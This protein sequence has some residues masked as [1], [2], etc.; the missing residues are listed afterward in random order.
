MTKNYLCTLLTLISLQLF[1]QSPTLT[2]KAAPMLSATSSPQLVGISPYRLERLDH[3]LRELI[4]QE[5][6]PGLVA[7]ISRKGKIVYEKAYGYADFE[8]KR[9][10]RTDD[11]FRIASMTK[12]ITATALMMLYE[13][14][15][16]SLDDPIS[17]WIPEFLSKGIRTYLMERS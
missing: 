10:E 4:K 16:F 9:V 5:K 6:L 3:S 17:K 15:K 13:E 1:S 2:F 8:S 14:G 11:I 12:A 7:L